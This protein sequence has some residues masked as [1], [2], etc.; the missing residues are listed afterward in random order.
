MLALDVCFPK[1]CTS[2][3]RAYLPR[4]NHVYITTD[5]AGNSFVSTT[6]NSMKCLAN[7]I[8]LTIRVRSRNTQPTLTWAV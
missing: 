6:M 1:T 2:A 5:P 4:Q 8:P 7:W 3:G